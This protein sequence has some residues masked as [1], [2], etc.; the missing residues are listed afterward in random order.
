MAA[1]L[2]DRQRRALA[3]LLTA[4]TAQDAASQAGVGERTLRRW[5][6]RPSFR[7]AYTEASRQ[8]LSEAV[9]QLRAAS[10]EAVNVLRAALDD[11]HTGH[12][13]RAA[14]GLLDTAVKVEV[15]VRA[16]TRAG[17]RLHHAAAAPA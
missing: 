2:T 5:L 7:V 3:A 10:A 15:K 1:D 6:N 9:G 16:Q 17:S 8:R 14:I 13:I 12:R 11:Q 4:R